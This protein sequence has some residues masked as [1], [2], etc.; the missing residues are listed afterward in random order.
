MTSS[1]TYVVSLSVV[2]HLLSCTFSSASHRHQCSY[3]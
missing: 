3:K 2:R 1:K